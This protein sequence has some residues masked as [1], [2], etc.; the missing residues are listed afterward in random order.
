MLSVISMCALMI[1]ALAFIIVTRW[2]VFTKAGQAG[3]KSI[4]PIYSDYVYACIATSNKRLQLATLICAVAAP[5]AYGIAM[6]QGTLQMD[7]ASINAELANIMGVA[8]VGI[9]IAILATIIGAVVRCIVDYKLAQAFDESRAFGIACMTC[10][11]LA[12]AVIAFDDTVEYLDQV[13]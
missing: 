10:E 2:K 11:T 4:I 6:S 1:A 3:W 13:E 9:C 7:E 8:D 5:V 12:L